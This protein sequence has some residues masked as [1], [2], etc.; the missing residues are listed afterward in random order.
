MNDNDNKRAMLLELI[1]GIQRGSLPQPNI[2]AA[3]YAVA[4][5]ITES[6]A[7]GRLERRVEA[8]VLKKQAGVIIDGRPRCVYW[9]A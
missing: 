6:A 8:G 7:Y 4:R 5:D 3:E 9:Q 2:T 1:D